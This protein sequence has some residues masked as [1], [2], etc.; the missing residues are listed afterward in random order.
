MEVVIYLLTNLKYVLYYVLLQLGT[1]MI[2]GFV[3]IWV[4]NYFICVF[5]YCNIL[6]V[7]FLK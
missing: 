6:I 4:I 7:L 1:G 5:M 3:S 2:L